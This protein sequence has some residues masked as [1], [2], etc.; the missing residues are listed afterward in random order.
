M[1]N[2]H[3]LLTV[4]ALSSLFLL[5]VA[6]TTQAEVKIGT[7]DM[8][9]VFN[10]YSKTKE[11]VTTSAAAEAALQ[12]EFDARTDVLKKQVEEIKKL[13]ADIERGSVSQD[14]I[15]AKKKERDEKL[16]KAHALD[17]EIAE[18]KASKQKKVQDD[19][20]VAREGIVKDI[21]KAVNDQTKTH[22]FNLVLD[23]SGL[24][25]AAVPLVLFSEPNVDMSDEVLAVLNKK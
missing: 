14:S 3:F 9:R 15:D 7:V 21:M 18:F 13:N 8:N 19:F 16:S 2:R 4:T 10:E 1:F 22:G 12:K 17:Q 11:V 25:T 5:G 20:L 23:K 24:T 6:E